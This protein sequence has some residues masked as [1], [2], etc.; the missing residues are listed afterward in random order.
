MSI[1]KISIIIVCL[2]SEKTIEKTLNSILEQN[3]NNFELIII[4]GKS[5]DKTL[6][7]ISKYNSIINT[8]ISEEDLGIYDAMNK[9]IA[10]SKFDYYLIIG[11]DDILYPNAVETYLSNLKENIDILTANY[12]FK[13]KTIT[14]NKGPLWLYGPKN[15][16]TGHSLGCVIK[17]KL[18]DQYGLYSLDFKIAADTFFL[19]KAIRGNSK[20]HYCDKKIGIFGSYGIS[21]QNYYN[22]SFEHM[23]AHYKSGSNIFLQFIL[24]IFKQIYFLF[25]HL[26]FNKLFKK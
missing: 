6:H 10:L 11:S 26:I 16:I 1:K 22:S 14:L 12:V 15:Y 9:G 19:L 2:N 17:K 3:N 25:R 23:I 21:N 7:I 5:N 4:D 20:I 8:F 18:H 24:F 13:N